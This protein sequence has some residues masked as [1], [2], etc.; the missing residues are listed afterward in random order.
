MMDPEFFDD[1]EFFLQ[2]FSAC[3][4]LFPSKSHKFLYRIGRTVRLFY[5]GLWKYCDD[6]GRFL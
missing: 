4:E 6:C 1:K 5:A 2:I 3:F